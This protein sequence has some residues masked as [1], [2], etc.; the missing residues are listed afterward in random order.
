MFFHL[1]TEESHQCPTGAENEYGVD[2]CCRETNPGEEGE[3]EMTKDIK[4]RDGDNLLSCQVYSH[5]PTWKK[6]S[7]QP[8]CGNY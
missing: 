3:E 1:C 8:L 4:D 2:D 5:T 6:L 7:F